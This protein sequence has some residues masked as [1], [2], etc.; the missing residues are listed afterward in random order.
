MPVNILAGLS[1]GKKSQDSIAKAIELDPKSSAAYVSRGVGNYYVPSGFGGGLD[2]AIRDF[3][4]AIEL[5]PDYARAYEDLGR[6]YEQSEQLDAAMEAFRKSLSIKEK[7][8][9]ENHPSTAT[10]Y[11]NVAVALQELGKAGEALPLYLKALAIR[12]KALGENHPD[13]A[14]SYNNVAGC[15]HALG[16][17]NETVQRYIGTKQQ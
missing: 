14:R 12:E 2:L 9:G 10:S 17:T 5:N 3:Q 11:N 7:T 16:K 6:A 8:V 15:L 1:Y 13:V 4:K